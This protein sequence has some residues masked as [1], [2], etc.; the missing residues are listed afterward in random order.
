MFKYDTEVHEDVVK[1]NPKS[2]CRAFYK[3][4]PCVEDV[5]N[6]STESFNNSIGKARDKPYV[7]MLETIAR[8][9]M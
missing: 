5:E 1:T 2:W 6:N 9:A 8:L 4:G 7:P 3:V